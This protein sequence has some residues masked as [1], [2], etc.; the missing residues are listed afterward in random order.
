MQ[1]EF[2]Y[3]IPWRSQR[4]RPGYHASRQ[5]G[6]GT[7]VGHY[8]PLTQAPDPRRFDVRVSLRDPFE[9]TWVR[10][11]QQ[12]S[13]ITVFAI[14]DLSASMGFSGQ[15]NKLAIAADFVASLSLSAYRTGDAFGLIGCDQQMQ[16]DFLHAPSYSKAAGLTLSERLRH[17][18]PDGESAEG[19]F[20]AAEWLGGRRALIFLLSDFHFANV[21]LVRLLM[22]F[23]DHDV[24]PIV[25]WDR[26]EYLQLPR[27]GI[28]RVRDPETGAQRTL[29]MRDALRQRIQARFEQRKAYLHKLFVSRGRPPLFIQDRFDPDLVTRYFYQ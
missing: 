1:A 29:L 11:Y 22:A 17:F 16:S 7:Q 25:L 24:V 26:A 23:A 5:L 4:Y 21:W 13:A 15:T 3:Q 18:Q 27:F 20:A 14:V 6:S 8:L 10:V 28:A 2:H 19:L 12:N 9:Q